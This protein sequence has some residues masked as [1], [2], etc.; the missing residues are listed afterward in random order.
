MNPRLPDALENCLQRMEQGETLDS[1]LVQYSGMAG[2]L[3]P[4]LEAAVQ[5]RSISQES[6]PVGVLDGGNPIREG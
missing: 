3:R 2:E 6:L 1:V 5:A 4:L